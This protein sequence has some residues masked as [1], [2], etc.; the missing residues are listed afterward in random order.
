MIMANIIRQLHT[1]HEIY[2]FLTAYIQAVRY[3]DKLAFLPRQMSDLPLKGREDLQARFEQ[4]LVE[5]D[6]ASRRLDDNACVVIKEAL[7]VVGTSLTCLRLL[8]LKRRWSPPGVG[9]P[10][11]ASWFPIPETDSDSYKTSP[12]AAP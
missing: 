4:L 2:F 10:S 3:C 9:K 1:E 12:G 6:K 5:L 8:Q 11:A 7:A